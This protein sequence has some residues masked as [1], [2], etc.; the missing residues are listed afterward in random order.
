MEWIVTIIIAVLIFVLAYRM[1]P[2]KGVKSLSTKELKQMLDAKDTV[3]IDVRT[4]AEYKT[5]H[6]PQFQNM[7]IG[8]NFST[9]PKD[10]A[11]I[12]ICQSGIRSNQ[13]CKQ[14]MKLGY[15]DV[16]NVRRGMNGLRGV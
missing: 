4:E 14:L 15:T 2:G 12:V 5:L 7:R 9:L 16:T 11:I 8:S 6:I 1:M 10:Q 13:V 3:F